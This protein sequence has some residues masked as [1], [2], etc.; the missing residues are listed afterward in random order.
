MVRPLRQIRLCTQGVGN[1]ASKINSWILSWPSVLKS[2]WTTH[3]LASKQL[4]KLCFNG[5]CLGSV[6][7]SPPHTSLSG[8]FAHI[9]FI[10]H[11]LHPSPAIEIGFAPSPISGALGA[12][13]VLSEV[14]P[15]LTPFTI[16]LPS[17]S[18]CLEVLCSVFSLVVILTNTYI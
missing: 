15:V 12:Q 6:L 14:A 4:F 17:L 9:Y 5:N 10:C 11:I 1:L 18:T 3:I 16:L 7:F 8:S 2:G 13:L